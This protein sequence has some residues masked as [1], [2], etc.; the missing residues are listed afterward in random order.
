V[1]AGALAASGDDAG[2]VAELRALITARPSWAT[3]IRSFAT[4]RL[5][6]MPPP[7][8]KELLGE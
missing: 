6:T 3:I 8:L 7:A 5:L 1:R 4:K 2:V